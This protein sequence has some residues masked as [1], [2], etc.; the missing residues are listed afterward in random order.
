[1]Y[2]N[3]TVTLRHET[4]R[5]KTIK[6]CRRAGHTDNGTIE[7]AY[8][9]PGVDNDVHVDE[10]GGLEWDIE[11]VSHTEIPPAER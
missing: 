9:L 8:L 4:G 6:N 1:M 7:V 11:S 10:Y 5:T 3:I 2:G